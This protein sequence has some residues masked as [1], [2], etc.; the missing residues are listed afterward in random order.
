M[1]HRRN[2]R[3][4]TGQCPD[5][6]R[7]EGW[8]SGERLRRG[9]LGGWGAR[10]VDQKGKG[11]MERRLVS[12]FAASPNCG[13]AAARSKFFISLLRAPGVSRIVLCFLCLCWSAASAGSVD[14]VKLQ[15]N[16]VRLEYGEAFSITG[17]A[18]QVEVKDQGEEKPISDY[19][20]LTGL[21]LDYQVSGQASVSKTGEVSEDGSFSVAVDK[22]PENAK[23]TFRFLFT[24]EL[25]G[26]YVSSKLQELLSGQAFP[27]SVKSFFE[28]ARGENTAVFKLKTKEFAEVLA[29]ILR[30]DLPLDLK[31]SEKEALADFLAKKL[32]EDLVLAAFLN[33]ATRRQNAI[34][35][36]NALAPDLKLERVAEDVSMPQLRQ[37]VKQ[38]IDLMMAAR[39]E[40]PASLT[41]YAETYDNLLKLFPK[42]VQIAT[43]FTSVAED[44][45]VKDF[46]KYAGVD[47][48]AIYIPRVQELR[49]FF[50]VNIYW[51]AVEDAPAPAGKP[52]KGPAKVG[53]WLQQRLSFSV[54]FSLKDLSG[55][56]PEKSQVY[57]NSAFLAGLGFRLNKYFRFSA[58]DAIV[59][60][61][62]SNKLAHALYLGP[63]VDITAL[64]NLRVLFGKLK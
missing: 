42:E 62:A 36:V 44:V 28:A 23:V 61:R 27:A 19:M 55:R 18:S 20:K 9:R 4:G 47:V 17:K 6:G 14:Y 51:G 26:D 37:A 25:K 43:S 38:Q 45:G 60:D 49:A 39:K 13:S 35:F 29:T 21:K 31:V 2:W 64:Q 58:G 48:G 22:L 33:L 53:Q 52:L 59:R 5:H 7:E 12:R 40:V 15:K 1:A 57:S 3:S 56:A 50:T 30:K 54:G 16:L 41:Q 10:G 34:T 24:G 63:S 46:E 32:G 8:R 11:N